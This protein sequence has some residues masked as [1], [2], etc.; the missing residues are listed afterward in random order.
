MKGQADKTLSVSPNKLRFTGWRLTGWRIIAWLMASLLVLL[1][2]I[3]MQFTDEVNWSPVDFLVFGLLV[4]SIGF[5][6]EI[7][8]SKSGNTLYRA[9]A[10]LS[11]CGVFFLVW[12]SLGVGVIGSECASANLLHLLVL[13]VGT[14]GTLVAKFQP[15]G[16][17]KTLVAVAITQALVM[18]IAAVA[19]VE[20]ASSEWLKLVLLNGF[21]IVLFGVAAWLFHRSAKH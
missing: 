8:I 3:A 5:A 21:F 2:L 6:L 19:F 15:S 11:L 9:A 4:F 13:A 17:A 20:L 7:F 18:V 14:V 10:G 16:M 1:P 12:L